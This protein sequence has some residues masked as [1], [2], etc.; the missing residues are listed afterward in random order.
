MANFIT[1]IRIVLSIFLLFCTTFS[2]VFYALYLTAGLTD[3]VD[4]TVA[5]KTGTA[6]EF[7]AKLD[8]VADIVFTAVCMVMILPAIEIPVWIYLWIAGIAF[9]KLA[10]VSCVRHKKLAS[11][12][13]VINKAAGSALFFFPLGFYLTDTSL[14]AAAICVIATVA[15][16][17]ESYS[18]L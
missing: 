8:T 16:I 15:A 12:H 17:H 18:V 13:S 4:G 14:F 1:G 5:R 7:G 2:P 6:S 11:V 3:M 10:N 9:I